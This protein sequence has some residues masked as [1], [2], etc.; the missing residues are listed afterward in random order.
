MQKRLSCAALLCAGRT[1]ALHITPEGREWHGKH[2][3][4][5]NLTLLPFKKSLASESPEFCQ[6]SKFDLA[7]VHTASENGIFHLKLIL[8][9]PS[10][11]NNGNIQHR[12]LYLQGAME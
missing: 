4:V 9:P 7:R 8:F 2:V 1:L 3:F 10:I 6:T 12:I 5:P 11:L